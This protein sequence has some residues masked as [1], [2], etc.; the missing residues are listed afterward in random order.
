MIPHIDRP[1][2][3]LEAIAQLVPPAY[4]PVEQVEVSGTLL[5]SQRRVALTRRDG[6]SVRKAL[7]MI[8]PARVAVN[9]QGR[10][11]EFDKDASTFTLRQVSDGIERHC[12]VEGDAAEAALNAFENDLTVEVVGYEQASTSDIDVLTVTSTAAPGAASLSHSDS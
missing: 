12:S 11:R 10:V 9:V 4:G 1:L 2:P 3:V 7:G 8:A 5:G 6:Q